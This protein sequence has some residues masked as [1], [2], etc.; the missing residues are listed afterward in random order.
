VRLVGGTHPRLNLPKSFASPFLKV[1]AAAGTQIAGIDTNGQDGYVFDGIDSRVPPS[2]NID[3]SAFYLHGDSDDITV[4]NSKLVGGGETL[5]Q[6]VGYPAWADRAK[7]LN[8]EIWGTGIDLIHVNGAKDLLVEGNYLHDP[9]IDNPS[10]N[11][12]FQIQRAEGWAVLRNVIEWD[13]VPKAWGPNQGIMVSRALSTDTITSGVIANNL[14]AHWHG[15]RPLIV[16]NIIGGLNI[17][18]NT[19]VDSGDG[20]GITVTGW[21]GPVDNVFI[22]NNIV[23]SV[24]YE[25][26][27]VADLLD[28]NWYTEPSRGNVQG[29]NAYTGSPGFVVE[30]ANA[31]TGSAGFAGSTSYDLTSSSPARSLGLMRPGTPSNTIDDSPRGNPPGLGAW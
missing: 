2:S 29:A 23:Q 17:V 27:A 18:N 10:H 12:A 16:T 11:D 19:I 25:R 13:T 8:N 28:T 7:I 30:G 26:G 5:K 22:W 3:A 31:G 1:T 4:K 6:Y 20:I 9:A 14:I 15:G 21:N 24:Y